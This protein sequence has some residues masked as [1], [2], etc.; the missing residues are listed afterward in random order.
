MVL[1]DLGIGNGESISWY[2]T[3]VGREGSVSLRA[4]LRIP[5]PSTSTSLS[6]EDSLSGPFSGTMAPTGAEEG[7]ISDPTPQLAQKKATTAT[8]QPEIA[9]LSIRGVASTSAGTTKSQSKG[10]QN[11]GQTSPPKR[12]LDHAKGR[13]RLAFAFNVKG[14]GV[15]QGASLPSFLRVTE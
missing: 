5:L 11:A 3:L 2:W 13:E 14:Q 12:T 4:S 8:S 7:E 10:T 9:S 15:G 6:T 1:Y